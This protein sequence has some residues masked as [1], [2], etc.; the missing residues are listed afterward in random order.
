MHIDELIQKSTEADD[1]DRYTAYTGTVIY[2]SLRVYERTPIY[3]YQNETRISHSSLLQNNG[4]IQ[5]HSITMAP[6]IEKRLI[7]N[8]RIYEY[9][10]I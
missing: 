6:I 8:N 9:S 2:C 5:L 3:L 10:Y 7:F 4:K 1:Y